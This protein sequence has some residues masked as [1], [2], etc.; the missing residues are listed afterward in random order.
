MRLGL[1][2]ETLVTLDDQAAAWARSGGGSLRVLEAGR[3]RLRVA[4]DGTHDVA[5]G[6]RRVWLPDAA[7]AE[8]WEGALSE[9]EAALKAAGV[10]LLPGVV[11][12]VAPPAGGRVLWVVRV[13]PP[14]GSRLE[15]GIRAATPET[16][17]AIGEALVQ[18]AEQIAATPGAAAPAD[19]EA[20]AWLD[21]SLVLIHADVP[22]TAPLLDQLG[23]WRWY[24]PLFRGT[25][26]QAH[27][28]LERDPARLLAGILGPF[29]ELPALEPLLPAIAPL[30]GTSEPPRELLVRADQARRH[31]S[32]RVQ[33]LR[34]PR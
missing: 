19:P 3:H 34:R 5:L 6:A 18:V 4:V 30:L 32:A 24:A 15:D 17:R 13:L 33:R 10:D 9:Q 20:W 22:A 1:S 29:G 7:A 23:P 11:K 8:A 16:G 12:T 31:W 27:A 26:L 25:W 21:G 2:M 14:D 28:P